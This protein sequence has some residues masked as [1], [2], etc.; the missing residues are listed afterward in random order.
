M[1][2]APNERSADKRALFRILYYKIK[3]KKQ[4][5]FSDSIHIN[6]ERSENKITILLLLQHGLLSGD[7]A[8]CVRIGPQN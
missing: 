2:D 6:V 1:L 3:N 8:D 7:F 5:D 4:N